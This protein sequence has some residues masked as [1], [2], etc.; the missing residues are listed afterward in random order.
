MDYTAWVKTI[1]DVGF[2]VAVAGYLLFRVNVQL[3]K[4]NTQLVNNRIALYLILYKCNLMHDFEQAV[5][6]K[7]S[8]AGNT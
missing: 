2:P 8:D 1:V 5:A 7:E 4:V 6:K 3:E